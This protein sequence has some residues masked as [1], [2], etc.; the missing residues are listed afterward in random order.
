MRQII[1]VYENGVI[2]THTYHIDFKPDDGSREKDVLNLYPS[3]TKQM[4]EG[5]G[6]A[7]TEAAGYVYSQLPHDKKEEL[8]RAYFS[9]NG[10]GYVFGRCPV[11]SCDF[12]LSEY[13]AVDDESDRTLAAFSLARDERY[14]FP[15]IRDA[16][17]LRPDL[18]FMLSPWSP[19]AFMKSN[20]RKTGGGRL[21]GEYAGMWADYLC[22]YVMEYRQRGIPVFAM[23]IQNEPNAAQK[24]ESCLFTAEEERDFIA[25]YLSFAL[26][27]N[28]LEDIM[29][30]IWDHNK[31]RLFDR[32][33]AVLSDPAVDE[34]VGAVGYHWYS[35][36]HFEALDLVHRT[37][38]GKKLIFTEG[39]VEHKYF[40]QDDLLTHARMYAHEIIN[41]L[42]H[43]MHI[44]LDWNLC[45]DSH[46]GPNHADNYCESPV[47]ATESG[48][49]IRYNPSYAYIG[50]FS[51]YIKPGAVV[52][53]L[54]RYSGNL[55]M[56]ACKNPDGSLACVIS[57][58]QDASRS[59]YLRVNGQIAGI[60]LPAN[61]LSTFL[62][63]PVN[64]TT[65][66]KT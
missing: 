32:A 46:G 4:F 35:G 11:D 1:S 57:N 58:P 51:R 54:S 15:L 5:F 31:E 18:K 16:Q 17:K 50:H 12:S 59:C 7:F 9:E 20:G 38:P 55:E 24:W 29:L 13:G 36:D 23:S 37:Y 63:D 42:N 27:Q 65:G 26:K 8:M 61:S 52:I 64:M 44:F 6:G 28:G 10:L 39:C 47:M 56:T 25:G 43:G 34:A 19:P 3:V 41:G 40:D 66:K 45:L 49:D 30:T 48:D 2:K 53:G 62:I 14:I 22:R 21:R 60:N 33:A